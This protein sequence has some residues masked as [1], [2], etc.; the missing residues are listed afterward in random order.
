[1]HT[2]D[3]DASPATIRSYYGNGVQFVAWCGEHG[4]NPATVT[5]DDIATYGHELVAR[6]EVGTMADS[7]EIGVREHKVHGTIALVTVKPAQGVAESEL[8]ERI[9]SILGRYTVHYEVSIE[10][11]P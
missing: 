10:N 7:I 5:E 11:A 3:G 9:D 6:Y 8:R 1:M 2:T 4:I